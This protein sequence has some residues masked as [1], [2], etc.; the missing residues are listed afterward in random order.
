[1]VLGYFQVNKIK[2]KNR[3]KFPFSMFDRE[4]AP[5]VYVLWNA[6]VTV[7]AEATPPCTCIVYVFF[8]YDVAADGISDKAHESETD[9]TIFLSMVLMDLTT[10]Y[11]IL[12]LS[13]R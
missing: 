9:V 3:G 2:K 4:L 1:M 8:G 6:Y 5:T 7:A 10:G 13:I 12:D 11:R